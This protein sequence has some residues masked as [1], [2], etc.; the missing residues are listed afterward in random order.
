MDGAVVGP[1]AMVGAGALVPPGMVV[2]PGKLVLGSPAKVRRDLTPGEL[3]SLRDS[4][5]RYVGYAA[6]YR[7]GGK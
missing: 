2:P 4:A 3:A 1:D 6:K 5:A 7:A